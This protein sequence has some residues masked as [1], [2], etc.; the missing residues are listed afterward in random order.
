MELSPAQCLAD[1]QRARMLNNTIATL[2]ASDTSPFAQAAPSVRSRPSFLSQSRSGFWVAVASFVAFSIKLAIAWN[3]FGTNDVISFYQ[4]AV[5]LN[6]HGLEWT[7]THEIAFNH[8]P[9]IAYFLIAIY[10]LSQ[11]PVLD[12]NGVSFPFLLRFPGIVADLVTVWVVFRIVTLARLKT[13]AWALMLFALSPVSLMISGFHGNTDP[14]MVMFL[15]LAALGCVQEKPVLSGIFFAIACQI[16]IIPVLLMPMFFF[17]WWHRR[18]ALK[19]LSSAVL[20]SIALWNVPLLKFPLTF[21]ENVLSYGSFWGLWGITYWL[22]LTGLRE[23]SSVTFFKFPPLENVVVI[24]LKLVIIIAVLLI[25]WR[26]RQLGPTG[27]VHSMAY[28]WIIFFVLSPGVCAQYM[29]WLAPF[30]L[31]LWPSFYAILTATST[32]FLFFFY[33]VIS[34][35]FPWY[36]AISTSKLNTVWTPWSAWPWATLI[37]GLFLLW[38]KAIGADPKLR[39]FS[40]AT[41]HGETRG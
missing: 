38:R 35:G 33:N 40:I 18:A 28:A 21:A 34:G 3:T 32:L 22:R 24:I 14:V 29:I 27:L 6:L 20:I 2:G 39:L 9:L 8:P 10:K 11:I 15:G 5:F 23:F 7:Y 30:V 31:L 1:G 4:F 26:R 17:Y 16:K 19:Y 12:E 25:A 37:I 36:L 41:L 13:P